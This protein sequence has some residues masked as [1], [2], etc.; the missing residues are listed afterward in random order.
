MSPGLAFVGDFHWFEVVGWS[1]LGW[2]DIVDRPTL[3]ILGLE[4]SV[5]C[6]VKRSIRATCLYLFQVSFLLNFPTPLLAST[7]ILVLAYACFFVSCWLKFWIAC[8]SFFF[9]KNIVNRLN[10]LRH[11]ISGVEMNGARTSKPRNL[12]NTFPR[13]LGRMVNL[14]DLNTSLEGNRFLTEK[15]H[16]DGDFLCWSFSSYFILLNFKSYC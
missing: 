10:I 2:W 14:L 5:F 9:G 7:Q 4:V 11:A 6:C 8:V 12:E 13:C 1:S 15:P 16:H 3:V